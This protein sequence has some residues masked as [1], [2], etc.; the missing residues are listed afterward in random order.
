MC[1]AISYTPDEHYF[2]RT[3]DTHNSYNERV[4]IAPRNFPL[5]FKKV[6]GLPSHYGMIG[7]AAMIEDY[8]L[9]YDA[10]NEKGLSM[11]GLNFARNAHYN[12][13]RPGMCNLAPY[14]LIPYI[15]GKCSDVS[16]AEFLLKRMNII[17]IPFNDKLPLASLHWIV[18]DKNRSITVEPLKDRLKLYENPLGVLTNNPTFNVQMENLSNY[19]HLTNTPPENR[20]FP[21]IKLNQYSLGMG[22]IGIPGDYSSMSRFVRAAHIKT[23]SPKG[24][25]E[26]ENVVQFF[27]IMNSVS[28]PKGVVVLDNG[29]YEITVYTSC[30]NTQKGIYYYTTYENY[31]ITAVDMHSENLD[32]SNLIECPLITSPK[33][34][35]I[36]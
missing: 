1:T 15:L 22:S 33:I 36:K 17:D 14:E 5:S 4:V 21:N 30:C 3:L 26:E 11:A 9:Y 31:S 18:S 7:I 19:M 29:N 23:S 32:I 16:E 35:H 13:P 2:G 25:C 10:A 28:M 24:A 20:L 6:S 8:P 12:S 27:H 34:T